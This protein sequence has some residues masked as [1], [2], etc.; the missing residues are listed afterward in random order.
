MAQSRVIDVEP[1]RP[2]ELPKPAE[3]SF[4]TVRDAFDTWMREPFT[5]RDSKTRPT[6]LGFMVTLFERGEAVAIGRGTTSDSATETALEE[7]G[8]L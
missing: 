3:R 4:E 2:S 1:A 6:A 7:V 5:A 8:A